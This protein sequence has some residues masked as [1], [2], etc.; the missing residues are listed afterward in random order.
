MRVKYEVQ[1]TVAVVNNADGSDARLEAAQSITRDAYQSV[2]VQVS[3]VR[4][5]VVHR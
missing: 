3:E 4:R 2:H 5:Q 1:L